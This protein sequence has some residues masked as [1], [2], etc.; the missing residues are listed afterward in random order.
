[1]STDIIH[2]QPAES[3]GSGRIY[4]SAA[5]KLYMEITVPLMLITFAAWYG[6]YKFENRDLKKPRRGNKGP[7]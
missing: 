4:E 7:V 5:L 3:G 2:F 6:V 1:M